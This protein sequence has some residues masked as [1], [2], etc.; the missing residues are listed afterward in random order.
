[1]RI[2]NG[3]CPDTPPTNHIRWTIFN[4][5]PRARQRE[6]ISFSH[7]NPLQQKKVPP[8][9]ASCLPS[10][11][12]M[13]KCFDCNQSFE[14]T[15]GEQKFYRQKGF[16]PPN[17][18]VRWKSAKKEYHQNIADGFK[19][20]CIGAVPKNA[21]IC[22]WCGNPCHS[23]KNCRWKQQ[24]TC[25]KCHKIGSPG[26]VGFASGIRTNT[27]HM[28]CDCNVSGTLQWKGCHWRS[29]CRCLPLYCSC[30]CGRLLGRCRFP[31]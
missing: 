5:S 2:I 24:A 8:A 30:G 28:A 18:C 7:K 15:A 9:P 27:V 1:M 11:I 29:D 16:T 13:L 17:R 14:F 12:K 21:V 23:E 6:V 25:N 26:S 22:S 20:H 31:L 10:K 19:N 3:I 4:F